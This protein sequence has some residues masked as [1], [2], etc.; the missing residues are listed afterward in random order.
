MSPVKMGRK[1]KSHRSLVANSIASTAIITIVGQVGLNKQYL[2]GV[3]LPAI[4]RKETE[5][6]WWFQP[7]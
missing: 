2:D 3:F 7:N 6:S 5:T 4:R 1:G